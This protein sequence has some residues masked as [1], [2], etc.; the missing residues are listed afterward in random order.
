MERPLLKPWYRLS[1]DGGRSTLRYA[2]SVLEFEGEA[3]ERLLPHLLP[4]LDGTRSVEQVV[5]ELGEPVRPA[6][7]HALAILRAHDLLTEPARTDRARRCAELLAATDPAGRTVAD[8]GAR[9]AAVEVFVLGGAPA[10]ELAGRLL[11]ASGAGSVERLGWD[12]P[13][14][15]GFVVAAPGS[16]EL[17]RLEEWN[18]RALAAGTTWLQVLPFDGRLAAVGPVFVPGQTACHACFLHRRDATIAPLRDRSASGHGGAP[19]LDAIAA[20]LAAHMTL[21]RLAADDIGDSGVLVAVEAAQELRCTRHFVHRVP[22]CPACSRASA[23][24]PWSAVAA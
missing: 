4:L 5:A 23:A 6:I 11:Q 16:G 14:P 13:V 2:G 22:R 3:A 10:A 7:E 8:L 19:G 21:R 9:V 24:L 18:R 12:D 17:P 15:D 20:G 1:V